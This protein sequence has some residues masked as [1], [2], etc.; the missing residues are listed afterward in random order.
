[1]KKILLLATPLAFIITGFFIFS[2]S[3]SGHRPGIF[4]GDADAVGSEDDDAARVKYELMMLRDP[5][6]GKIPDG[7]REKELAFAATLPNDAN[8]GHGNFAA[9]TTSLSW[10]A[11]GPWNVGGRTR[12]FGIDVSNPM[13]LV[14]GSCSGGMWRS[15]DMGQTWIPT[16][17]INQYK[18]VS[19]LSQDTRSGHTNV[20]YYGTGEAFGSSASAVGA[21]YNGNGIFKSTDSG[22]TWAVLPST[23][24]ANITSFS[25]W[26]Q[27]LWNIVTNSAIDTNDVVYAAA[28]GGI[29]KTNDGGTSWNSVLGTFSGTVSYFT[30]VAVSATGVVY[31]TLSSDGP[32]AGI[33]RSADGIHFTNITPSNFPATYNRIKI[34][35]SPMDETQIYFVGNTPGYGTPD[36][37]F[38]GDVEWNSLW[39]YKYLSDSGSGAGGYW[40][41]LSS[42]LPRNGGVFDK[43]S[44]QGSYD[45]VVKVKPTD[46]NIV[47]IGGTNLYRSTSGFAD[48][49]NTTMIGGYK[50]GAALPVVNLYQN[51]HPDQHE[52]AFFPGMPDTMI[53]ANDGGIFL[54]NDNTAA[55]VSWTP[56]NNGY[57]TSMFY[58]CA[59]DHATTDDIVIGGA[60]DNGSWYT[61]TSSL[62]T[63]WVTP[64]GGDGS[65]CAIADNGTAFYFSS[66]MAKIS[67]VKLNSSGGIDSFTRIDPVG[68][69]NYLFITPF[70]IDPNNNDIMYLSGGKYLW[71]NNDLSGIP[72][73]SNW[74]SI[75]TNWVQFPDS[76]PSASAT[77]TALAISKYPANRLYYGTS[78]QKVYRID[79]ANNGTPTPVDITP[80]SGSVLF[81]PSA[82][83]S[84]IAVDPDSA[85]HILV[86]F[87]N[88]GVYSLFYSANGGTTW[89]KAAGNLEQTING[90]GNGPSIRWA[91]IMPVSNGYVYMVGTSV[92]LYA[93]NKLN[94]TATRWIQQGSNTIGASVVDMID[95]RTTDGLVVV[96]THSNVMFSSHITDTAD[97]AVKPVLHNEP[98]ISIT[99][100]PNPFWGQTNVLLNLP[101]S[102][103]INLAIYNAEGVLVRTLADEQASAGEKQYTFSAANLPSGVYYCT[104][105][106]S[107]FS[108]TRRM[109]LMR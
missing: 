90:A 37:N 106:T 49:S 76:V 89:V 55:T 70:V 6:T 30:D 19:C 81:P 1:V 80:N 33:Y 52:L 17:P 63:P 72:Y 47:F 27:V 79:N 98:C 9:K 60:Q 41:D 100:F 82:Y 86:A 84:C 69:K 71:R 62:T 104:L 29:M 103:Y 5:A 83:V 16:T 31:A 67:R 107:T 7:I 22:Q 43:Y 75:S 10:Q 21:Y 44:T 36:T 20:W 85:D 12:A 73:A 88:Y 11:R 3:V 4:L 42:N 61:N 105:K 35:I 15:T 77:I 109:L 26:S 65:Y 57:I 56:L 53:S 93:T 14:A 13:N 78:S 28:Y 59:I 68:G 66:Q 8:N 102:S 108:G 87:S 99:N 34:G 25:L 97:V 48:T 74:D 58:T 96:A 92:G 94:G 32:Q 38:L 50:I 2:S 45:I 23:A 40:Q 18:S 64:R 54:T 24:P 39:K 51:H 95:Y 91:S 46:T 101:T